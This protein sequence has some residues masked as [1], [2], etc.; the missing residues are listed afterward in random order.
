MRWIKLSKVVG[1]EQIPKGAGL[2]INAALEK[3][4]KEGHVSYRNRW[5]FLEYLCADYLAGREDL[6]DE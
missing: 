6:K 2:V 5:Q 1:A 4:V 3:A